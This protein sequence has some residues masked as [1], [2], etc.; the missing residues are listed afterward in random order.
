MTGRQPSGPGQGGVQ[1]PPGGEP[2]PPS[3]GAGDSIALTSGRVMRNAFFLISQPLLLNLIAIAVTGYIARVLGA[4]DFG[5]LNYAFAMSALF[6]SL[7]GL[8]IGTVTVRDLVQRRTESPAHYLGR[9]L[10]LRSIAG[11]AAYASLVVAVLVGGLL[12][13][14][15]WVVLVAGTTIFPTLITVSI[16]D[17][18]RAREQMHHIARV[19]LVSGIVLMVCSVSALLAGGRLSSLVLVYAAAPFVTLVLAGATLLRHFF[20]PRPG[21]DLGFARRVLGQGV[22]FYA[23]GLMGSV[24]QRIDRLVLE[25]MQGT[26]AVG[27]FAAGA[28]LIEKLAIIP[29]GLG[30][31][32]YPTLAGLADRDPR[33]ARLALARF[34]SLAALIGLPVALGG[35]LVARPLIQLIFGP[36]YPQAVG[37]FAVAVWVLPA[38]CFGQVFSFAVIARHREKKGLI[39]TAVG[40]AL[41]IGGNLLLV[42]RLGSLGSA[43]ALSG[44]QWVTTLLLFALAVRLYGPVLEVRPLLR[45][46]AGLLLMGLGVLFTTR[47]PLFVPLAMGAALYGLVIWPEARLLLR[48]V[49]PARQVQPPSPA[50]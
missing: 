49:R 6:A 37:V 34:V 7:A 16:E 25:R 2:T 12:P 38:W 44:S 46:L 20:V 39:F 40:T 50:R 47:F 30:G 17:L 19:R 33:A 10:V 24:N 31:A 23:G 32:T 29:E 9:T 4:E 15:P 28:S 27:E 26:L 5:R 36:G 14:A 22:V 43:I 11:L 41:L 48:H 3:A 13:E 21:F 45:V 8:G 1:G 42:P 18:F 35:M